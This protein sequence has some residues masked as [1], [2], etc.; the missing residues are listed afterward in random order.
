VTGDPSPAAAK[1]IAAALCQATL[2]P[3]GL[4]L[5]DLDLA[6]FAAALS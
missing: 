3:D 1:P 2:G 4:K 5:S 6:G